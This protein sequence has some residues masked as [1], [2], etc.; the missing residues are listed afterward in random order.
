MS[1]ASLTNRP[2]LPHDDVESAVYVFLKV[3][4]QTFVPPVDQRVEWAE[5]LESY[6]WDDPNVKLG[7]LANL[8][9][10]LWKDALLIRSTREFFHSAGHE[11]CARLVSSLVA[12]PLPAKRWAANSLPIQGL[13]INPTDYDEIFSSL[14]DLVAKA[15]AAVRAVDASSLQ[16][17]WVKK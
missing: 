7:V 10:S 2:P 9:D 8:R 5:V 17:S 4:T 16:K 15:V 3:L 1:V 14:E 12:L 11:A 6:C 13:G